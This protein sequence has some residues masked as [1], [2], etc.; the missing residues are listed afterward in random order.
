MLEILYQEVEIRLAKIN[1][2]QLWSNFHQ[3]PFALYN[4][5]QVYYNG[6]YYKKDQR[7]LA[8]TVIEFENHL[9][10]IW[11]VSVGLNEDYDVLASNLVHEM[12]HAF[13]KERD[14]KRYANELLLLQYP[15]SEENLRM[16]A[17]ENIE[18]VSVL[19]GKK[20]SLS[21]FFGLR[22]KRRSVIGEFLDEEIKT[23]LIE[24]G[25]E[26]VGTL[27]LQQLDEQKFRARMK[28]YKTK[29]TRYDQDF[30]HVRK[31]AYYTGTLLFMAMNQ[32]HMTYNQNLH[33]NENILS[34]FEDA[35]QSLNQVAIRNE[36]A[37][38][39]AFDKHTKERKQLFQTFWNKKS[40]LIQLSGHIIGFDPMNSFYQDGIMLCRHFIILEIEQERKLIHQ[41][42]IL[43]LAA[44]SLKKINGYYRICD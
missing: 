38:Q 19:E 43:Q 18:L 5:D 14:E 42:V 2:S 26:F 22:Q 24:G 20:E 41:P 36:S 30:F 17:I 39:H 25:A 21:T 37:F 34:R 27:A 16:K 44:N 31:L 32:L 9:V 3:Y 7:F 40:S 35:P 12:F 33:I 6:Q 13:Q 4:E 10:A 28:D 15:A 29:I 23:E 1:F 8:N 11:D